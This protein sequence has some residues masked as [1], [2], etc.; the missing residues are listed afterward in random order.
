MVELN[1]FPSSQRRGGY[2]A[3]HQAGAVDGVV[4][5]AK[6]QTGETFRPN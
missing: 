1:A 2:G 4:R 5:P 3:S 6:P